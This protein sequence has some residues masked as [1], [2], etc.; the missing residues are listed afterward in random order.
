MMKAGQL[1]FLHLIWVLW[2]TSCL[3]A[4]AC[5]AIDQATQIYNFAQYVNWPAQKKQLQFCV[6]G[7]QRLGVK[8]QRLIQGKNIQGMKLVYKKVSRKSEARTCEILFV[9][10]H[11]R[12]LAAKLS[13]TLTISQAPNFAEE[14][15][16]IEFLSN[17]GN[18]FEINNTRAKQ[19]GISLSA[20]L[21]KLAK[22]VY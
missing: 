15:G 12:Y 19:N 6:S 2:L 13:Q 11:R 8:L 22:E 7:N 1:Y 20:G 10:A 17:Q 4:P 9:N 14:I 18:P 3:C 21:L 5:Y 16:I